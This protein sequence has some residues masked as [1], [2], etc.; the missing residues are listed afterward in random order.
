MISKMKELDP[1]VE[2]IIVSGDFVSHGYSVTLGEKDHYQLVKSI[3]REVMFEMIAK[4]FP[5]A[6]ILPAIGNNDIQYHYV[7]P[8][9]NVSAADYYEFLYDITFEQIQA[10]KNISHQGDIE[11][12]IKKFGGYRYDHSESLSF[13]SL[14]TLYYNLRS[15]SNETEIKI[16][17]MQWLAKQ[18]DNA[19]PQRKFV[20][21]FHI[22]PGV[23]LIRGVT[24]FWE[25]KAVLLFNSIILR[26]ID[27]I[28]LITGS[29]SH[30][31][32]IRV[33]SGSEFTEDQLLMNDSFD[34]DIPRYALLI[35]PAISPIYLNNPGFTLMKLINGVSTDITWHFMELWKVKDNTNATFNTVDLYKDF[36]IKEF[37]PA[38]VT[39]FMK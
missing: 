32:D 13:I 34:G 22:Y 3:I 19:E 26:N 18:L 5:R 24:T 4:N 20:I 38:S 28:S 6:I 17:Q 16:L 1:D 29:H 10:N 12:P 30:F 14:N 35:T 21:F 23:S 27:K 11:T 15:P 7:A 39:D 37:T 9:I 2:V 8:Q 33:F 31:A 25:S 36:G